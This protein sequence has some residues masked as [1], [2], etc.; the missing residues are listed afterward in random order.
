VIVRL[1]LTHLRLHFQLL[2]APV[3]LW[4]WL[5]AGGGLT[6]AVVIGFVAFHL[7]LYTGATAFNSYYD[8]DVGPVGGLEHPPAVPEVLLPFSLAVQGI[9]LVLAFFVNVTFVVLYCVFVALS[10]AYSHPRIRVKAHPYGSLA[11]IAIGQGVFAF[12][13]AWSAVRGSLAGIQ[14]F[15]ASLASI[16]AALLIL[17]L[18]PLTQVYQVDEDA[19]RGDTTLAVLWGSRACC[20]FAAGCTLLGGGAMA[21][22]VL[23]R[24]GWLDTA[25]ILLGLVI[26]IGLMLRL[27]TAVAATDTVEV[28]R[29]VMRL[30]RFSAAALG[31][32]LLARLTL[33]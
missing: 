22:V 1:L 9:G 12:A 2:L 3:W 32:Y 29:R 33:G 8:R 15:E 23:L 24:F 26:Q 6:A 19:A 10:V 7:F 28:Y 11:L 21:L 20:A 30:A 13:A 25:L 17:A 16:A 18:Y 31:G 27:L 5:I 4:G 14:T